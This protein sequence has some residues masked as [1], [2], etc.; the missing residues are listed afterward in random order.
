[1]TSAKQKVYTKTFESNEFFDELEFPIMGGKSSANP[2]SIM[3]VPLELNVMLRDVNER[4]HK[5]IDDFENEEGDITIVNRAPRLTI[6]SALD[7]GNEYK[8]ALCLEIEVSFTH[9]D[10]APQQ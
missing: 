3:A 7:G 9:E 10:D 8:A 6:V 1:M 2:M 5:E 4:L